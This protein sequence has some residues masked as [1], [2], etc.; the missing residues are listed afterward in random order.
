MKEKESHELDRSTNGGRE[1]TKKVVKRSTQEDLPR[2]LPR[3]LLVGK[4]WLQIY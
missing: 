2:L 1:N 4:P 3:L